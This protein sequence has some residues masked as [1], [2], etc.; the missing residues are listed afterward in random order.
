MVVATGS[1][2]SMSGWRLSAFEPGM[3]YSTHFKPTR[4]VMIP[5][6]QTVV[7]SRGL[8]QNTAATGLLEVVRGLV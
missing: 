7:E 8:P 3:S 1:S 2:K 5:K 4:P 6:R